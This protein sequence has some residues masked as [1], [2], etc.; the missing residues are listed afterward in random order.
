MKRRSYKGLGQ[1]QLMDLNFLVAEFL[2]KT[3]RTLGKE[4][5]K[6]PEKAKQIYE[7]LIRI[8]FSNRPISGVDLDKELLEGV[9]FKGL[10][11]LYHRWLK[12]TWDV[13]KRTIF[14][15]N[16]RVESATR[17]IMRVAAKL[18]DFQKLGTGFLSSI[19]Q[20]LDSAKFGEFRE[21]ISSKTNEIIRLSPDRPQE[22]GELAELAFDQL[23]PA[24]QYITQTFP[25]ANEFVESLKALPAEIGESHPIFEQLASLLREAP[26]PERIQGPINELTKLLPALPPEI[27]K[28]MERM[29]E[30]LASILQQAPQVER[31]N[32]ELH[33]LLSAPPSKARELGA[34]FFEQLT[35]IW[36]EYDRVWQEIIGLMPALPPK[37]A[38]SVGSVGDLQDLSAILREIHAKFFLEQLEQEEQLFMPALSKVSKKDAKIP[39]VRL[40]FE[41]Y[42]IKFSDWHDPIKALLEILDGLPTDIFRKCPRCGRCFIETRKGKEYCKRQCAVEAGQRARQEVKKKESDVGEEG[43][44]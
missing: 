24:L 8:L 30:L 1:D 40:Y 20:N 35:S 9:D 15:Y 43:S 23:T 39:M 31:I 32:S 41:K 6:K 44:Q 25:M 37:V 7:R 4:M 2:E 11:F 19:S 38:T 17:D 34:R 28:S 16:E 5:G 26:R 22:A 10:A 27:G 36:Q 29:I 33:E 14:A 12:Q 21:L 42:R 13:I 3:E 18:D